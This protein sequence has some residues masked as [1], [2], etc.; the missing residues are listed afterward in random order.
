M[1]DANPFERVGHVFMGWATSPSASPEDCISEDEYVFNGI[2][3]DIDLY[4]IWDEVDLQIVFDPN[5]G[6]FANG[7]FQQ[8]TSPSIKYGTFPSIP[9]EYLNPT[10]DGYKFDGWYN[11]NGG[12]KIASWNF[13]LQ[14]NLELVAKWTPIEQ[15]GSSEPAQ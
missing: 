2:P 6:Q 11:K 15:A 4:A 1:L 14:D 13:Y 10:R 3:G 9:S 7:S 8:Y 5:G 12:L